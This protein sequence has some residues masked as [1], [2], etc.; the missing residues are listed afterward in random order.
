MGAESRT[1]TEEAEENGM[2]CF[3][4]SWNKTIRF[5]DRRSVSWR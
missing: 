4:R 1:E 5:F 3:S 2:V